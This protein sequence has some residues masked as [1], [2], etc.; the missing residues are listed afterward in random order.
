MT[1][2]QVDAYVQAS[3]VALGLPLRPDHRP[4]VVRYFT[5]A[6]EFAAVVDAVPLEPQAEPAVHFTPVVPR[7]P[8]A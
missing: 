7:E 4:G 3:A 2:A 6:A 1:P 8:A 5:I